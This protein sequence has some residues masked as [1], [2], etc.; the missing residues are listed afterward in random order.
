M[1]STTCLIVKLISLKALKRLECLSCKYPVLKSRS[2]HLKAYRWYLSGRGRRARR[3]LAEGIS[4]ADTAGLM[5]ESEWA[6]RSQEKWYKTT[7]TGTTKTA[8]AFEDI[9]FF[10]LP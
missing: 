10:T 3:K 5:Y 9:P 6:V 4:S 8:T 2:C 1:I 7:S